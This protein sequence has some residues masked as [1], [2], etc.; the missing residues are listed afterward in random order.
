MTRPRKEPT[1]KD[2]LAAT[3]R[4]LFKIP[5]D[6]AKL[7]SADQVISLAN[8]D[9]IVLHAH[10]GSDEHHNLQPLLI[11]DHRKK[12]AE[13]DV[14]RFAKGERIRAEHEDFMRRLLTPRADRTPKKSRWPSR[15]FQRGKR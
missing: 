11:A 10:G 15:P 7:M 3:L 13:V 14:P 2:K 9:H 5:Y 1:L 6:H 4:E 12:T 8:F